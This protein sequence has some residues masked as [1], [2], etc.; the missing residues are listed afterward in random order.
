MFVIII[1]GEIKVHTGFKSLES[2]RIMQFSFQ[3]PEGHGIR[4]W[5][6]CSHR[7]GLNALFPRTE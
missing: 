4:V 3:D 7:R 2:H 6:I 1:A 5:V